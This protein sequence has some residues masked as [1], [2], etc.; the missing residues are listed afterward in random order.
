MFLLTRFTL[1]LAGLGF[2]GFG[3]ACLIAPLEVLAAAG[4]TLTGVAAAAEIR[5]FYGGLEIGVGICLLL[6][7]MQPAWRK[8][9]LVLCLAAYG[10]IGAAR[11]LGMALDGVA[12]PFLWFALATELGLAA[13]AAICLNRAGS[14]H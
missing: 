1:W 8:A 6:A 9:G 11:A 10:G 3:T 5:A 13:L 4:V 2:V 7:A 14:S 12:T